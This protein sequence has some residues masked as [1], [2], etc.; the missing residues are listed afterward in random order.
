MVNSGLLIN[1]D[2]SSA[3]FRLVVL[4]KS[5]EIEHVRSPD[6]PTDLEI[7][8]HDDSNLE[9]I[10][11]PPELEELVFTYEKFEEN[12]TSK[13]V[14]PD[15]ILSLTFNTNY[16]IELVTFPKYLE[17]LAFGDWFGFCFN[18]DIKDANLPQSLTHLTFGHWFNE[19]VKNANFPQSLTHLAF[20]SRFGQSVENAN[21]PK[22]LTNLV[23]RNEIVKI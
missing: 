21:F 12:P 3:E 8:Y 19:D 1:P 13:I 4:Q 10:Y 5:L 6:L 15:T 14:F 23:I 9:D 18:Q 22:T 20:G 17:K 16:P 11:Y 7:E 2:L